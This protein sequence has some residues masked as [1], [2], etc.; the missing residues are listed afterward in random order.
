[1]DEGDFDRHR[2]QRLKV[3]PAQRRVW[4]PIDSGTIDHGKTVNRLRVRARSASD[5]CS[6]TAGGTAPTLIEENMSLASLRGAGEVSPG[7]GKRRA[8]FVEQLA[9][10]EL[11]RGPAHRQGGCSPDSGLSLLMAGFTCAAHHVTDA[12]TAALTRSAPSWSPP[13]PSTSARAAHAMVTHNMEWPSAG[14]P[15]D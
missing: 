4:A 11:G 8:Q 6:R 9:M 14:Q 2:I 13:S 3:D 1:M 10:P 15:A 12:H 7:S 5:G